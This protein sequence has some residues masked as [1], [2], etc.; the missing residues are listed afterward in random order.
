MGRTSDGKG[1]MKN[2]RPHDEVTKAEAV[3]VISRI[4]RDH[5]YHNITGEKRY[6]GHLKHLIEIGALE[7]KKNID[8][9]FSRNHFYQ[10]F[11]KIYTLDL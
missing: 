1:V 3:T 6:E 5:Q 7:D 8:N 10:L 4:F 11:K 2:F 9:P